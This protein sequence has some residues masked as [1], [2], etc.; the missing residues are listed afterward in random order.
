M[1]SGVPGPRVQGKPGHSVGGN[2]GQY[3][4]QVW[5]EPDA[6]GRR[7]TTAQRGWPTLHQEGHPGTLGGRS[8][9][10]GTLR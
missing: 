2:K 10:V 6:G 5:V 4:R 7:R 9:E 1:T 3:A 8:S